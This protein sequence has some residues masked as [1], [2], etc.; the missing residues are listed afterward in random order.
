ME[1]IEQLIK[2]GDA[3]MERVLLQG[4]PDWEGEGNN[5]PDDA[6]PEE[7]GGVG[8]RTERTE[9]T[10]GGETGAGGVEEEMPLA[11][12]LAGLAGVEDDAVFARMLNEIID[13]L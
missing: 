13:E 1:D 4:A 5:I 2:D 3:L 8:E 7:D 6:Y 11:S 10:A 12:R 9:R